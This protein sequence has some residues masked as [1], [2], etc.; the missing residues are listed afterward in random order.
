MEYYIKTLS[1]ISG[2][3]TRTLRYYDE[4]GLLIPTRINSS[5][6]RIYGENEV[7]KLQQI[8]FYKELGVSLE[9][10]KNILDDNNFST[11]I[12]LESHLKS[13]LFKKD[14]ILNLIETVEK[15]IQN[16][17]G[18]IN[19]NDTEK[20]EA[21]KD[22]LIEENNSKYGSEVKEKY[23]EDSLKI[24]NEKFKK[25]AKEDFKKG[26]DLQKK[27]LENFEKAMEISDPTSEFAI[28]GCENHRDWLLIFAPFNEISQEYH[29]GLTE[30]YC[31]DERFKKYYDDLKSGL[32]D[33]MKEA[34]SYYYKR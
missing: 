14:K 23:G 30:M 3:S 16:E 18:E 32:A 31:E 1:K 27:L 28:M 5:N 17:K 4:I 34:I 22:S 13:L 29:M 26:E 6:Y 2:V 8:M 25:L 20:F 11:L 19:M 15:T 24:A 33:F 12:A 9:D 10:I 21:F 7:N